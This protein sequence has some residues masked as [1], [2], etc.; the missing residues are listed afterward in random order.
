MSVQQPSQPSQHQIPSLQPVSY[1]HGTRG[2]FKRLE[3][4][5]K[6][7]TSLFIPP[8]CM[9]KFG[10]S[11]FGEHVGSGEFGSTYELCDTQTNSCDK[12]VKMVKIRTFPDY[13]APQI[14]Y[15]SG[16]ID[17]N[18]YYEAMHTNFYNSNQQVTSNPIYEDFK[19]AFEKEAH[20]T[21]IASDLGVAPRV[22]D[23][24]ICS[25][26][27]TYPT[28][29]IVLLGFIVMDKWDMTLNK[30]K[31]I[32]GTYKLPQQIYDKLDD[33]VNKLHKADIYHRDIKFDNIVLKVRKENGG[34]IVP[35]DIALIDYGQG[36]FISSRG[37]GS[38][39]YVEH[40]LRNV[41]NIKQGIDGT[42][43]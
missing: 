24:F 21:Q 36:S 28:G 14:H 1:S 12:I 16:Y 17:I 25:D 4:Q 39:T 2:R 26:V 9:Q 30:F 5:Q 10:T 22:Y 34:T 23:A 37:V 27:L 29:E 3:Q 42:Y 7:Q 18:E 8:Q 6:V 11:F 33:L 41:R 38:Y 15:Y 31:Q 35:V 13:S 40:D 32:T 43:Q 19:L 20:I